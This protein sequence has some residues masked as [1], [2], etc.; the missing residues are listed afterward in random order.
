MIISILNPPTNIFLIIA[1]IGKDLNE[2]TF[3]MV[4][5]YNYVST[6]YIIL[7]AVISFSVP[8]TTE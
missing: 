1:H 5:K 8:Q 7:F 4:Y 6:I 2:N 3:L